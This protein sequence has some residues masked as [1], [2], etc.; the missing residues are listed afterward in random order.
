LPRAHE[1]WHEA[2]DVPWV[3]QTMKRSIFDRVPWYQSGGALRDEWERRNPGKKLVYDPGRS[4]YTW[5]VKYPGW[6]AR[7]G[8]QQ[9]ALGI[10]G[11][12]P[13]PPACPGEFT[14][15]FQRP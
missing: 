1:M 15:G 4:W 12:D 6:R 13:C 9:P 5:F 7:E 11:V 8:H 3:Q 2:K 14:R 10:P